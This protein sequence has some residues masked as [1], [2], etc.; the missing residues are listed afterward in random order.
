MNKYGN[1]KT[2]CFSGHLHDSKGEA[3]YCDRLRAMRDAREIQNYTVQFT[4]DLQSGIQHVVDFL[5]YLSPGVVEV[6][7]YK[8]H[9]T[10]AWRIKRKLFMARYPM[11][12]YITI[13]KST[14]YERIKK[15][16]RSVMRKLRRAIREDAIA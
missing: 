2:R 10:Q 13:K 5:V 4:F 3:G 12:K 14:A 11:I 15:E 16:R 7:E 8:G 9:E 1:K 6:H